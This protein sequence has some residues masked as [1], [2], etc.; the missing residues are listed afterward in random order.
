MNSKITPSRIATGPA[1]LVPTWA[2]KMPLGNRCAHGPRPNI[3]CLP[4]STGN[5]CTKSKPTA[6]PS[7]RYMPCPQ[8]YHLKVR[9]LGM[10][11]EACFPNP[12]TR[13]AS[14]PAALKEPPA[15]HI[16][17]GPETFGGSAIRQLASAAR[18]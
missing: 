18:N 7:A 9:A 1:E 2:A 17:L 12:T 6:W 15:N 4:G 14:L 8:T 3:Q 16:R 13:M 5:E 11:A 10:Q